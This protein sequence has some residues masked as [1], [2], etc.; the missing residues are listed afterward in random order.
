M[1]EK[2]KEAPKPISKS[3]SP[4]T[5]LPKSTTPEFVRGKIEPTEKK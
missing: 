3:P 4:P 2:N 1:V 5:E